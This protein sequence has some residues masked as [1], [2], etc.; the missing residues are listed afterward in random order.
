[1]KGRIGQKTT[2]AFLIG[3]VAKQIELFQAQ[4][5]LIKERIECL[6]EKQIVRR[7]EKD[8]NCYDYVA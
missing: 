4:P 8:R 5:P 6:I 1:M 3:D 7:N 2:H